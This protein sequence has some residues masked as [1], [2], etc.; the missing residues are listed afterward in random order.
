MPSNNLK[1]NLAPKIDYA[2]TTPSTEKN[3]VSHFHPP[4]YQG[5]GV[6]GGGQVSAGADEDYGGETIF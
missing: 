4:D 2:Y 1:R 3:Q 6:G 5:D